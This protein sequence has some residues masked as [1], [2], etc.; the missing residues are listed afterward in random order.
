MQTLNICFIIIYF[1]T[2][3]TAGLFFRKYYNSLI[4][5]YDEFRYE[6]TSI[7]YLFLPIILPILL[8]LLP[9]LLSL[10]NFGRFLRGSEDEE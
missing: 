10:L 5:K 4:N 7:L 6:K 3:Y 1:V 2:C 8:I 9:I